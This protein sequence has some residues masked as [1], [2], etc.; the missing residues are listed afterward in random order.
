MDVAWRAAI[1]AFLTQIYQ[2]SQSKDTHYAYS[3]VLRKFFAEYMDPAAVTAFQVQT[4]AYREKKYGGPPGPGAVRARLAPL[5]SFYR[6]AI[7]WDLISRSPAESVPQPPPRRPIPRGLT[8]E[9]VA[10]ILDV[11]PVY[12]EGKPKARVRAARDSALVMVAYYL[13]LRRA[14]VMRFTAGHLQAA[15]P[16]ADGASLF[17]PL[18]IKGGETKAV[19]L[20]PP[21]LGAIRRWLEVRGKR[22]EEMRPEESLWGI[23][24]GTFCRLVKAYAVAAGVGKVTPHTFRHATACARLQIGSPLRTI[25]RILNHSNLSTTDRYLKTLEPDEDPDWKVL[26]ARLEGCRRRA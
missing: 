9:Q 3:L 20:V 14:E 24:P 7:R 2:R 12:L 19:H 10:R 5:R 25:S 21:V 22:L 6:A 18:R 1:D 11:I 23:H 16:S 4:F 26:H 13:A 17:V 8:E 15:I